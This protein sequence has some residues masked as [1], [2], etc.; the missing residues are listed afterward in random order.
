MKILFISSEVAGFSKTGGLADVARA[1][2]IALQQKG[3]DVRVITPLYLDIARNVFTETALPILGVPMGTREI[4]CKVHTTQMAGV[5]V[6]FVEHQAYF[7]R[8]SLYGE[9]Q[10]YDDNMDRFGFFSKAAL[11][12]CLGMHFYPD[13]VHCNDWHT[14][15]VP[16]YLQQLQHQFSE[17]QATY[18]LFTLH[19]VGYQG[20][21][22]AHHREFLSIPDEWF[23]PGAFEYYGEINFLKGGIAAAHHINTVSEGYAEELLTP[24]GG[25]G[26][27]NYLGRRYTAFSGILN[28]C[29]YD[30]WNPKY[31]PYLSENYD[32]P[33][34]AGKTKCKLH[35]QQ[36]FGL[37][38]APNAP[39]LGIVSRLT[40]Q[41][42]FAYLL[43]AME[44]ILAQQEVQLVVLGTGEPWIV[45]HFQQLAAWF[46]H[47]VG[48]Y[49][50]YSEEIAHQIEAGSDF[51]L[52]PSLYE[53]CGLNQIYSLRY[54]TLPIVRAVG[55]LK[56]TVVADDGSRSKGTG[57]V[58]E[59]P[60][61]KILI[62]IIQ[63]AVHLY[64]N[65]PWYI[66]SLIGNAM[67]KR[68]SWENSASKY[69]ELYL[70]FSNS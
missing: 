11:Q 4:F 51:F 2:P 35:L 37:P 25:H 56:D 55:G 23:H 69:E 53:P 19:N 30:M 20:T 1:L 66:R 32:W 40:T 15:L 3:H 5:P 68:F 33:H 48:W 34:L 57:F 54:G 39:I 24:L 59:Q 46:P 41:K 38:P 27:H 47:K 14:G 12:F 36:I 43:P 18:S 6:Y 63:R 62:D 65:D 52:M 8:S 60:D 10:A 49:H 50:G 26:L 42:G 16:L 9:Q 44:H 7:F 31:D 28:G 61:S 29:D 70:N 22:P 13:I 45:E 58:F 64:Y 21:F 17:L 67:Q